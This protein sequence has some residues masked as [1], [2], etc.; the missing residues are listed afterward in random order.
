MRLSEADDVVKASSVAIHLKF[1]MKFFY[2]FVKSEETK[3]GSLLPLFYD[4]LFA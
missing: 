3:E 4:Y 2:N 1:H